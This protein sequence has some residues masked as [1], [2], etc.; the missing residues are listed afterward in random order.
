M[1]DKRATVPEARLVDERPDDAELSVSSKQHAAILSSTSGNPGE[2]TGAGSREVAKHEA[3]LTIRP[4]TPADAATVNTLVREI[5]HHENSLEH[6]LS[7][8]GDWERMLARPD[9][10][11]LLAL[12]GDIPLGYASTTWR[13]NLWMG[14]DV[15]ALDDLYVREAARNR[16]VGRELMAAVA[17][18]ADGLT[19]VW[20]ARLDNGA[21]HRFYRRLGARLT[22]KVLASWTPRE[23]AWATGSATLER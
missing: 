21:G 8:A 15:L 19:I 13:I 10:V 18:L 22:T 14:T 9:V 11:V 4:A 16:G 7:R 20:G 3:M 17:R 1:H 12:E 2:I 23:Y 6:V 5:A